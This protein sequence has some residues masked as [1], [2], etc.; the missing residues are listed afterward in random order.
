MIPPV[1]GLSANSASLP[2]NFSSSQ[3]VHFLGH[4]FV[5]LIEELGGVPLLLP[6]LAD[7]RKVDRVISGLDGIVLTSGQDLSPASYG[8]AQ[9]VQYSSAIAGI[10]EAFRRPLLSAPNVQRDRWE[11]ALYRAARRAGLPILGL[12]RGM[13]LINAAEGGTLLQEIPHDSGVR[14]YI[15]KDG[16]VNYHSVK[17]APGSMMRRLIGEA[18]CFTSS[19]HHQAVDRPGRGLRVVGVAEDGIAEFLE[20]KDGSFVVGIQ[21]HPEKTR[22]NLKCFDAVFAEFIARASNRAA[23][24]HG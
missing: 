13:Q 9:K 8:R 16:W 11:I 6:T 22:A 7:P 21:G 1:I 4:A 17:I 5:D 23:E 15:E 2:V 19:V 10:G 18:T 3:G 12:C 20:A 14:H 24:S